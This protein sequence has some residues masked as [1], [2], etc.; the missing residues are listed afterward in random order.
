[1]TIF[2]SIQE[3]RFSNSEETENGLSK[4]ASTSNLDS[5][6]IAKPMLQLS[7][8]E[9]EA[10]IKK[11]CSLA[12]EPN[13]T[14]DRSRKLSLPTISG[15][16]RSAKSLNNIDC[17]TLANLIN[18]RYSDKIASFRVLDARYCYEFKG[19][20]IKGAENF[21]A[22]DEDGFFAEFLPRHWGPN[23]EV[24]NKEE[25]AHIVIFHCEFSS[26]RGPALMNM[27][28]NR[29]YFRNCLFLW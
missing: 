14:G 10:N 18:G 13:L 21:G 9:S 4:A 29:Y 22:W 8:S 25:K 26:A 3:N 1:M 20:H 7:L 12:D 16:G 23:K 2:F 27:L 17:H 24:P 28:R 5:P 11:A 6:Q 19:G 15:S